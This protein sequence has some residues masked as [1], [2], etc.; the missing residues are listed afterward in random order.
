MNYGFVSTAADFLSLS[1]CARVCVCVCV[2]EAMCINVC[3][4]EHLC[5]CVR[6]S[7]LVSCVYVC[8]PIGY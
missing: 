3:I 4:L 7:V 8:A 5:A 1:L 6:E 2:C